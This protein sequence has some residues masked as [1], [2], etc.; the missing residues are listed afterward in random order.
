MTNARGISPRETGGVTRDAALGRAGRVVSLWRYPV[1][2]LGGERVAQLRLDRRGVLGDRWW[3]VVAADGKIGSG[4]S[5]RRFRRMPGL[6]S[7]QAETD[8]DGTVWI[9]LPDGERRKVTDP[10]AAK[11]IGDVV[12]EQVRLLEETSTSHM[13]AG[14]VHLITTGAI[15]SL[16]EDVGEELDV[17]RFRPNIVIDAAAR[18]DTQWAGRRLRIGTAELEID[19]PA[20]RCVMVTMAQPG[21]AFFPSLLGEIERRRGRMFGQYATV[22]RPG[23]ISLDDP[24]LER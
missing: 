15:A 20:E 2:S 5:T 19:R 17:R 13:D 18:S 24:V 14:P 23:V 10:V 8:G 7:L 21:V 1:K 9:R 6:L 3:A 4:K 12:G 11:T 22:A 16:A